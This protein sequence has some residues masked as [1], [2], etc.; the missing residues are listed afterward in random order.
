MHEFYQLAPDG[1]MLIN[2]TGTIRALDRTSVT[3]QIE[4]LEEA[5]ADLVA[6]GADVVIL[7][8]SPL[9]THLGPGSD[10]EARDRL[11][12][13][14]GIPVVPGITCEVEALRHLG[15][16]RV[17]VATPYPGEL[18]DDLARFL[19]AE[20]FT[21]VSIRGA[22]VIRNADIGAMSVRDVHRFAAETLAGAPDADGLLIACARW[23]TLAVVA[24]LERESGRPVVA[25]VQAD[26]WYALTLLGIH[27]RLGAS[28]RL[29]DSLSAEPVSS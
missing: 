1:L 29:L 19:E 13:K 12:A 20:R 10:R 27:E 22:R 6:N 21:V 3:R 7:G 28:S 4:R 15:V 25:S 5:T 2:T 14:F 24:A 17:A 26:I 16:A 8:G 11:S 9:F 23:P 18:D